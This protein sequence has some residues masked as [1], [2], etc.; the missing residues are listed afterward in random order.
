MGGRGIINLH[1]AESPE[2]SHPLKVVGIC[3]A[4]KSIIV[5]VPVAL[6]DLTYI[7]LY[8]VNEPV[9]IVNAATPVAGQVTPQGLRFADTLIP[10]TVYVL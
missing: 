1:P 8:P 10:A 4:L 9:F 3:H 5:V 6:Y 7:A 2:S